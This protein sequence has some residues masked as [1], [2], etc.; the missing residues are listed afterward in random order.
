MDNVRLYS[1]FPTSLSCFVL[2]GFKFAVFG[3]DLEK[4]NS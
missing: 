3:I 2:L 1:L 4:Q